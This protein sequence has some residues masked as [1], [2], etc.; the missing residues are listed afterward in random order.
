MISPKPTQLILELRAWSLKYLIVLI[1]LELS[2]SFLVKP[3]SLVGIK[4]F[5]FL[6]VNFC[7]ERYLWVAES[8]FPLIDSKV[9]STSLLIICF[10][11][12]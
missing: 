8:H 7:I 5:V 3:P 6:L 10:D 9:R 2:L 4:Y 11:T 12:C 1:T